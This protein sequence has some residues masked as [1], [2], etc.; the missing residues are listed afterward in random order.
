MKTPP[1]TKNSTDSDKAVPT[2]S[3]PTPLKTI[4]PLVEL[5]VTPVLIPS[6]RK[7]IHRENFPFDCPTSRTFP[8]P[9]FFISTMPLFKD[10]TNSPQWQDTFT[11]M[12]IRLESMSWD[13]SKYGSTQP[14]T[15]PE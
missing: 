14:S 7:N 5:I 11:S 6:F 2:S 13:K 4:P 8:I 10:L 15:A 3:T 1:T 9:V 12:T